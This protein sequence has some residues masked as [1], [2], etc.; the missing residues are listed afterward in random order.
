MLSTV[1]RT[2][3]AS[4]TFYFITPSKLLRLRCAFSMSEQALYIS[5]TTHFP[6]W[7]FKQPVGLSLVLPL[8]A[9]VVVFLY[10]RPHSRRKPPG[11]PGWPLI[12]NALDF[13]PQ[14][15]LAFARWGETYG[16]WS[17][18]ALDT[19]GLNETLPPYRNL[20]STMPFIMRPTTASFDLHSTFNNHQATSST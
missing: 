4:A 14:K 9:G 5:L 11:P 18:C 8:I 13:G 2:R 6:I 10:T 17:S 16:M 3:A 20:S 12:G 1:S 15:W 19:A 7:L